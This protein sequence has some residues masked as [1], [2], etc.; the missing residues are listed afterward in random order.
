MKKRPWVVIAMALW[1]PACS[2]VQRVRAPVQFLERNNPEF[3]RLYKPGEPLVVLRSPRLIGDTIVGFDMTEK[4]DARYMLSEFQSMDAKQL[5]KRRTTFFALSSAVV[6]G[7]I[8]W[9]ISLRGSGQ[10][11]C[12]GRDGTD[13]R[14]VP[15]HA[16]RVPLVQLR[17][18]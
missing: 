18:N 14:D 17:T 6:A 8:V 11:F 16:A 15:T 2:S 9:G 5:D 13:C 10:R 4:E 7:F 12:E 3:V 1:L